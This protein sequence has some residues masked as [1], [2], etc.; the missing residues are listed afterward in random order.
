MI[1]PLKDQPIQTVICNPYATENRAPMVGEKW[2]ID[3]NGQLIRMHKDGF[4]VPEISLSIGRTKAAIKSRI[5][6][7]RRRGVL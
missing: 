7:L 6:I 4:K 2:T 5:Q 1:M 3:Q